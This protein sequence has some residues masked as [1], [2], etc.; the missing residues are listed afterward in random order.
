L[1][2]ELQGGVGAEPSWRTRHKIPPIE[3]TWMA[4]R[5]L[6]PISV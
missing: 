5:S 4:C 3:C 2:M 1:Q 6:S